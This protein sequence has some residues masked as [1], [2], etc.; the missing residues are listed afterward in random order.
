M[1]NNMNMKKIFILFFVSFLSSCSVIEDY[2]S[3]ETTPIS[4]KERGIYAFDMANYQT[5]LD[6]LADPAEKGDVDSQYLVGMIH[7]YGLNG[8]KNSYLAQKWLDI[9]AQK[10]HRAAQEQLAF[11]YRDELNPL[12]N[13]VDAYY[14][15]S[16]IIEDMP[17]HIEKLQNL[18]WSLRSRGLLAKAQSMPRPRETM[19]KGMNYNALFPLR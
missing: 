12:Y 19:Y 18:E 1:K 8:K 14:W 17:Q 15:F 16:I 6:Y 3:A 2:R 10:G 5:S 9:A 7:L 4:K 13:P 11:L